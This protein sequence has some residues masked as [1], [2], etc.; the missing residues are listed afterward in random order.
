MI[1]DVFRM[2]TPFSQ[3]RALRSKPWSKQELTSTQNVKKLYQED[4]R[5]K[6]RCVLQ[7]GDVVSTV[8]DKTSDLVE[9]F[10]KNGDEM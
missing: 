1:Q 2:T 6:R 10:V 4:V 5:A 8:K 3:A 9:N 7:N